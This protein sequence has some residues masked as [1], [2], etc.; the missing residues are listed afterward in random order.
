MGVAAYVWGSDQCSDTLK[1]VVDQEHFMNWNAPY[2]I[3]TCIDVI[4]GLKGKPISRAHFGNLCK[5]ELESEDCYPDD[6]GFSRRNPYG[7]LLRWLERREIISVT[8]EVGKSDTISIVVQ[9]K[10]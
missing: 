5:A 9:G 3:K 8:E 4:R 10:P 1:N 2:V 6:V 7:S